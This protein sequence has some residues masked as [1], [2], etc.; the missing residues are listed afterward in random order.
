MSIPNQIKFSYL[1]EQ[2]Q[3][4][5][6]SKHPMDSICLINKSEYEYFRQEIVNIF[7]CGQVS[8]IYEAEIYD[9]VEFGDLY[10]IAF[11]ALLLLYPKDKISADMYEILT[12]DVTARKRFR[13]IVIEEMDNFTNSSK[14]N[15]T[16]PSPCYN[17]FLKES[18]ER[19]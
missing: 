6:K 5:L 9:D 10:D 12:L 17:A 7:N 14:T 4:T 13:D 19:F 8:K 15:E 1:L 2:I 16:L 11:S 18:G 3:N